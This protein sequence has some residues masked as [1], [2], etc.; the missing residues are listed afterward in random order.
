MRTRIFVAL[1]GVLAAGPLA[2][3]EPEPPRPRL[4]RG[5]DPNDWEAYFDHGAR[6][7]K[8]R[9]S[10]AEAA[11]YWASR[12]EPSRAE[13]LYARWAAFFMR[14]L[15]MYERYLEDDERTLRRPDVQRADS[16]KELAFL[17][18]PLVHRGLLAL[19]HEQLPGVWARDFETR[20]WLAYAQSDW[21]RA[22][23]DFARA[24]DHHR[25]ER[26]QRA[27]F[28]RALAFTSMGRLDSAAVEL[29]GLLELLRAEETS[30][31]RLIRPE[32]SKEMY[33]YAVGLLHL[34]E[35]RTA[36]AREA[37][38]RALLENAGFYPAH[39]MLG[40]IALDERKGEEA[41]REYAQ[42]VEIAGGDP[43]LRFQYGA[44]LAAAG[45][46]DEA[47][48]QLSAAVEW[49]PYW[50]E[51]LRLL[52]SSLERLGKKDEALA[53]YRRYLEMAPRSA[54]AAATRVRGRVSALE[55]AP[56]AP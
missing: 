13:P 9:T 35:R 54:A 19:L 2:A 36:P 49:E 21:E 27:R 51:P 30:D 1:L 33:E 15:R 31:L 14:D 34:A 4:A 40:E 6:L 43:V 46:H 45:R 26:H 56:A 55:A 7:F 42:A 23:R 41:V 17:R 16:L 5:A 50:A 8:G 10:E 37:F 22:V 11:F 24:A 52:G 12:L 39:A 38:Q 29:Q 3:Q 47:A 28:G 48:Q 44:A 32:E 53:A 20:A 18:N 25:G